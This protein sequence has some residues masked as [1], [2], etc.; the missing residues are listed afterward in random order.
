MEIFF[1]L[2]FIILHRKMFQNLTGVFYNQV[3]RKS[4]A[5][6]AGTVVIAA[7]ITQNG[8]SAGVKWFWETNN[9]GVMEI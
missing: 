6:Y 2:V 4:T 9:K 8:Y 3:W 1:D 5:L 7:L